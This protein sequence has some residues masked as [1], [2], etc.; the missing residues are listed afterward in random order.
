MHIC[1]I[2]NNV[3]WPSDTINK[4]F[5][6]NAKNPK[7]FQ[8]LCNQSSLII[9]PFAPSAPFLYPLKTSEHLT[10]FWCF[11][12]VEK[13]CI[14]DKWVN[15]FK[16]WESIKI[17]GDLN[18][19]TK[20]PKPAITRL[21]KPWNNLIFNITKIVY[22]PNKCNWRQQEEKSSKTKK[23]SHAGKMYSIIKTEKRNTTKRTK[24]ELRNYGTK[25]NIS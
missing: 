3:L 24:K 18:V 14:G 4:T 15:L 23:K 5:E 20:P 16:K 12:G 2:Q 21:P 6:N 9:N 7:E 1:C 11:Q 22:N 13:G 17:G 8:K 10:V 25:Y 19:K